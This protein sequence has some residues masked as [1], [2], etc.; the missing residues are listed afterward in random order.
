MTGQK[1][2]LIVGI[3]PLFNEPMRVE[4]V[5]SNGAASWVRLVGTGSERFRK[6]TMIAEDLPRLMVLDSQL[7]FDGRTVAAPRASDL[8]A[9]ADEIDPYFGLYISRVDPVPRDA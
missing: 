4:T 1:P 7:S 9:G 3:G 6:V 2:P 8:R 5:Q